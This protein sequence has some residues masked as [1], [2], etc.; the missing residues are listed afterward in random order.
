METIDIRL[1]WWVAFL[2]MI[3]ACMA[4]DFRPRKCPKCH[5]TMDE[6][7][8]PEEGISK[9]ECPKCGYEEILGEEDEE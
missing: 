8:D 1:I 2:I 7:Y 4:W 5:T 6:D 3:V 9:L